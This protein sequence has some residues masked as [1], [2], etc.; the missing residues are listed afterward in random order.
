MRYI[1]DL[2]LRCGHKA[3]SEAHN[4]A[5]AAELAL[6]ADRMAAAQG[7]DSGVE[8]VQSL[9]DRVTSPSLAQRAAASITVPVVFHV[10]R[11]DI[12]KTGADIIVSC[13]VIWQEKLFLTLPQQLHRSGNAHVIY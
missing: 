11:W 8:L 5:T 10:I 12:M 7:M 4:N 6:F 1:H 9:V 13:V 3:R 2:S